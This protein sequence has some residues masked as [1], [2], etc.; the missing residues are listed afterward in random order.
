MNGF[1]TRGPVELEDRPRWLQWLIDGL[2]GRQ[3]IDPEPVE[4]AESSAYGHGGNPS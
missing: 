4:G 1:P 3:A 2:W